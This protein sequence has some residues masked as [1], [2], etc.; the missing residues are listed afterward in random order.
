MKFKNF[1]SILFILILSG[2]ISAESITTSTLERQVF[3]LEPEQSGGTA[4]IYY[5]LNTGLG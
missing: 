5:D 4:R 3:F 2:F 1:I